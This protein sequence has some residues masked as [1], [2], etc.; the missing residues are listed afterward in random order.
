MNQ[1]WDLSHIQ[2]ET[3]VVLEGEDAAPIRLL[4]AIDARPL[5]RKTATADS[6]MGIRSPTSVAASPDTAVMTRSSPSI[7][8]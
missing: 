4:A 7:T 5:L 3:R 1:L 8:A 6:S 2:P